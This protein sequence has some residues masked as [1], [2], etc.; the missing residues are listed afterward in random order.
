MDQ[1]PIKSSSGPSL[2]APLLLR[3]PPDWRWQIAKLPSADSFPPDR[4]TN[5]VRKAQP[6]L[7]DTHPPREFRSLLRAQSLHQQSQ[8]MRWEL[9]A[10][11][12]AGESQESL[13]KR[14]GV[15]VS[16]ILAYEAV[17]CDVRRRIECDI[18]LRHMV[19]RVPT[20]PTWPPSPL[21]LWWNVI[22]YRFG[23]DAF[24]QVFHASA[25]GFGSNAGIDV[26]LSPFNRVS[27]DLRQ[28][29]A[30]HRMKVAKSPREMRLMKRAIDSLRRQG[31]TRQRQEALLA[32]GAAIT[33]SM[34]HPESPTRPLVSG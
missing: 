15:D 12:L 19:L 30:A 23:L 20:E 6:F 7:D 34:L 14:L 18:W 28:W 32:E 5:L 29:I 24:D 2:F 17:W 21:S 13:A 8:T 22:A 11:I 1:V 9:E 33:W 4:W 16:V 3:I 26:C 27:P 10:R 31:R 25:M